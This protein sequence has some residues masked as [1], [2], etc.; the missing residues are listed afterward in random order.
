MVGSRLWDSCKGLRRNHC[1]GLKCLEG[2]LEAVPCQLGLGWW[3]EVRN[4]GR[5]DTAVAGGPSFRAR[6]TSTARPVPGSR[7]LSIIHDLPVVVLHRMQK[8]QRKFG[9]F[10]PGHIMPQ[11]PSLES[12]ESSHEWLAGMEEGGSPL[13]HTRVCMRVT[14][15]TPWPWEG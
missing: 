7:R 1:A 15:Q 8:G 11:G 13:F 9:P 14:L 3:V 2:L 6:H 10:W 4:V 5:G 12:E